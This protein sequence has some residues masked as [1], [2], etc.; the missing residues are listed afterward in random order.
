[1][2]Y[3]D[4]SGMLSW[5]NIV[6]TIHRSR[7]KTMIRWLPTWLASWVGGGGGGGVG[8]GGG[9]VSFNISRVSMCQRHL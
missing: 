7:S 4:A 1:M 6:Q 8:L 9:G 3:I 2:K 5:L